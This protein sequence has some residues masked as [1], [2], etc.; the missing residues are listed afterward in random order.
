MKTWWTRLLGHP[1]CIGHTVRGHL[2]CIY[3]R[4]IE[5]LASG[6]L[7]FQHSWK[8]IFWKYCI[9]GIANFIFSMRFQQ[10]YC[11]P[12]FGNFLYYESGILYFACISSSILHSRNEDLSILHQLS[13]CVQYDTPGDCGVSINYQIIHDPCKI[14][15]RFY[16][17]SMNFQITLLRLLYLEYSIQVIQ[18]AKRVSA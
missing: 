9:T 12:G 1:V 11:I 4:S 15:G 6:I 3:I 13:D 16:R 2:Y 5:F 14:Y 7:Y 17:V 10:P 18:R 8:Q